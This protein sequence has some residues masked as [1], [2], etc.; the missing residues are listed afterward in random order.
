MNMRD[1][2][3]R[4]LDII[5]EQK[6]KN[7]CLAI[8]TFCS[9]APVEILYSFG[10]IPVRIWGESDNLHRADA[11]LQTF[12][13]PPARHLMALGLEGHYGFLD[14]VIH[15]YTCDAACGLYNI[16]VRNLK[17][18]FSHL[19][20]LPYM[21]I[22]EALTYTITEFGNFIEKLESFVKTEYSQES[23]KRSITLYNE[24]RSLMKEVYHL[25]KGS[26][27]ISYADIC[28]MNICCQ[29]LPVEMFLP[30]L[31]NFIKTIKKDKSRSRKKLKIL[32]SGSVI[33]DTSLVDFIE[34]AGGNIVA[35]DACTGL[36]L[37]QDVI[38]DGD[39]LQSLAGYYLTRAP[40]ASRA[41]FPSRKKYLL[42]ALSDFGIDAVIFIHQ[43]FCDPHLSDHPF[44]KK[45][46]D[47]TEIPNLQFE[48]EGEGLTGQV[49]TRIESFFEM[50]ERR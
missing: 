7:G 26:L 19:M 18:R 46:L 28:A 34:E 1:L 35:D 40:C 47:E 50:L 17:P 30:E 49:R 31:K 12:T 36:R 10:I 6:E 14:G 48:L 11:L 39:P 42:E 27:L 5:K 22:N 16:W 3:E 24:A 13:C 41:D 37:L 25:K 20:S 15:C 2:Y 43:K 23:L 4:R 33:S 38:P 29:T 32:I 45:I 21:A 8:G 44:L 9:Y